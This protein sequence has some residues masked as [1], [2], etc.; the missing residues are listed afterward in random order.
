MINTTNPVNPP[1]APNPAPSADPFG[2][3]SGKRMVGMYAA[4]I[5]F[6]N[7]YGAVQNYSV[8][9]MGL[10]QSVEETSEAMSNYWINTVINGPYDPNKSHD[11]QTSIMA[12]IEWD[13]KNLTGTDLSNALQGDTPYLTVANTQYNQSSTFFSGLDNGINQNSSDTTQT[14][15]IDLQMSQSGPQSTMQTLS[16]IWR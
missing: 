12:K 15:Q 2:N 9:L 1:P 16:Q 11:Q 4:L 14:L 8:N 7:S 10:S 13:E 6:M 5:S 3:I